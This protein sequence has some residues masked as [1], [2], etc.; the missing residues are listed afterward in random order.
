[1]RWA[2]GERGAGQQH[3]EGDGAQRG[4]RL[5][6]GIAKGQGARWLSASRPGP[7]KTHEA[8]VRRLVR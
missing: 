2:S 1:M 8:E 4:A 7:D 6:R 3:Q 5:R